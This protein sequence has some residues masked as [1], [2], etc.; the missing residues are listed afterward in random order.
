MACKWTGQAPTRLPR[1]RGWVGRDGGERHGV[2]V[3]GPL[4]RDEAVGDIGR[5]QCRV[6]LE[7]IAKAA[8]AAAPKRDDFA[9]LGAVDGVLADIVRLGATP[10]PDIAAGRA[11]LAAARAPGAEALA[12]LAAHH[13]ARAGML[14][15][16]LIGDAETAAE[17]A[18]PLAVR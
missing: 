6:A 10:G 17:L 11:G 3:A 2:N 1:G 5:D 8:A 13:D 9:E 7:R 12:V 16:Q 14:D 15:L 4:G 18:R